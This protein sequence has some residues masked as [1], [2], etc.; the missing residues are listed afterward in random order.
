MV[1]GGLAERT[2]KGAG[3]PALVGW[4]YES[5]FD[6][7]LGV[8]RWTAKIMIMHSSRW[9]L[10]AVLAFP[11]LGVAMA[12]SVQIITEAAPSPEG[13]W[14]PMVVGEQ[15][16]N[17]DGSLSVETGDIRFYRLRILGGGDSNRPTAV[18]LG[19]LPPESVK[20]LDTRLADLGR[21]LRPVFIEPSGDTNVPGVDPFRDLA[22]P[23]EWRDAQVVSNTI[24]VY[25][26]A[27]RGGVEPAY[28]EVKLVRK[29][30]LG[31][32]GAL[33][34]SLREKGSARGSLL[35][36]L[37]EAD[38]T[39]PY[40]ST[41]GETPVER[42]MAKVG[43]TDAAGRPV[44][45]PPPGHR[46]MRFGPTF[47]VLEDSGGEAIA[48]LGAQPFRP[49]ESLLTR[50]PK[51]DR[52]E[53]ESDANEPTNSTP[54]GVALGFGAYR[55][56][57]EFKRDYLTN[58]VYAELRN[59]RAARARAEMDIEAGRIPEAPPLIQLTPGST[60][61]LLDAAGVDGF[62]LDDDNSPSSLRPFV[63]VTAPRGGGLDLVANYRGEAGLIVRSGRSV[64]RFHVRVGDS[65]RSAGPS[66]G[67]FVPGWQDAQ[68]WDAGG[69]DE[70]PRYWQVFDDEWCS[71]VGCGPTA[72]AI[73]LGWWDRH[74]VPSA[75]AVGSG[76]VLRQSL[77]TED[78]PFMLDPDENP[79]GYNRV[80]KLYR[81]L[82]ES[83]QVM[84]F[85][86][87][88]DAGATAPGDMVQGWWAPTRAARRTDSN[89]VYFG[90]PLPEPSNRLVG[91]S[92]RW[93]WDLMDPDWNE[94][95]NVIRKA[96][97]SG[98]PA[99]VG[100]GWLWHYGV[101]YAYRYQAYQAVP[102]GAPI[103]VRRWFRVNEG[104]G[105][106]TGEWY[107]GDDTFLGFD[108]DLTQ[109][110]LPPP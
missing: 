82:H 67:E 26:P 64:Q 51:G 46:V 38:S 47:H 76:N 11:L 85:G 89:G 74:G 84:C 110:Y 66:G 10:C 21:F 42:L 48:S 79:G 43:L 44:L 57:A 5:T 109:R 20:R 90:H 6:N 100:L 93:A 23:A 61:H 54:M 19:S 81:T 73:L 52:S 83:C 34:G 12:A 55:N 25:D 33:D 63:K 50:F 4:M 95:S 70:Q 102:G 39:I 35:V 29:A 13:P 71:A 53:G 9:L 88:S 40:F 92:Y 62:F 69:Y 16:R 32:K 14:K 7:L 31:G 77:R 3:A 60:I 56:Y 45:T 68:V 108:L 17:A 97:K 103:A 80:I 99:I 75:F 106:D 78:A 104:W 105:K 58:P 65:P 15:I 2:P 22:G 59:R 8:P 18:H 72:W 96:N 30:G 98:R 87:F 94:P 91:Y 41:R 27:W 86:V 24:P 101:S 37:T 107:S 49:P 1:T 28:L 36:S